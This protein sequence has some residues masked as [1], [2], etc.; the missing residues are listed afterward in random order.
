MNESL[1]I[2]PVID[3]VCI[4]LQ[5]FTDIPSQ[6]M[7]RTCHCI[8]S[9]QQSRKTSV[10]KVML[11]RWAAVHE[12]ACWTIR[13]DCF[14]AWNTVGGDICEASH[15]VWQAN[16]S[17]LPH[18]AFVKPKIWFPYL[19]YWTFY[20]SVGWWFSATILRSKNVIN[21]V[22]LKTLSDVGISMDSRWTSKCKIS[23]HTAV[24]KSRVEITL[25][26]NRHLT[27]EWVWWAQVTCYHKQ[28]GWDGMVKCTWHC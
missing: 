28:D 16:T 8:Y 2:S 25:V 3:C 11:E 10:S 17:V 6:S 24:M 5:L 26:L 4:H 19:N 22:P 9:G 21:Y 12:R 14:R 20:K 23:H 18:F 7:Y 15:F 1:W 27:V 13:G